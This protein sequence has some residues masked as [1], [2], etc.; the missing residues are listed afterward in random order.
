MTQQLKACP[1][2]GGQAELAHGGP[3]NWFVRCTECTASTDDGGRDRAIAAWNIR[4]EPSADE[5]L[6]NWPLDDGLPPSPDAGLVADMLEAARDNPDTRAYTNAQ[7]AKALRSP[8]Q[9]GRMREAL[10]KIAAC[11][12]HHPG[13]VVAVARA[14]LGQANG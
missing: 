13:D 8:E 9:L 12:S 2:C 14:A 1:F 3:G 10:E 7:I 4:P 6:A 5:L 11:E